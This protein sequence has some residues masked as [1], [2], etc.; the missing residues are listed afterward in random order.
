[1]PDSGLPE[2]RPLLLLV[3]GVKGAIASTLAM[4]VAASRSTP[5]IILPSLTTRDKFPY[6]AAV[7]ETQIAGWD[8]NPQA[9]A[10]SALCQGIVPE[11][12]CRLHAEQL[13]QIT[14]KAAPAPDH[15][16][17]GQVDRVTADIRE[18]RQAHADCL[19]VFINLLPAAPLNDF[20]R[21]RS[22]PELYET[23]GNQV[24]PDLA[25]ALAAVTSGIPLVNFTPNAVEIPVLV[26][27]A[28]SR[29]VPLC[30]RDG[31]TGQTYFKV[32]LASAFKARNLAVDGW[33]SLNILGNADGK[34]LMEPERAAGKVA[35]KTDLL[36][37]L[38][39]YPVGSRYKSPSHKVHIDYYAPRGDAKEAWDVIDF[40]G[41][42]DLPMSLR[43]NL[44]GRDSI[45]AAPMALD[46]ARWMA[47][48]QLAGFGGPVPELGFFFKKPVG[49]N[50]AKT[51]EEQ[52]YSLDVLER[53][54]A[55][56]MSS[57]ASA[58]GARP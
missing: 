46:L 9:L 35:N 5:E 7:E 24:M 37:E 3:A 21:C 17:Q 26:E 27:E 14:V 10:S 12:V 33:Y 4:A 31:K 58:A 55:E 38:L 1:M 6:L 57:G 48:L 23:A 2:K 11:S 28:L 43:L 32:V 22:L 51:F 13:E 41:L 25:Y 20:D 34:N 44:Q 8:S 50:A 16:L 40:R 42:F 19:P 54:C 45:L 47:A 52:L 15:D 53:R 56:K 18:F 30:G 39:G 29:G 36:D 49:P